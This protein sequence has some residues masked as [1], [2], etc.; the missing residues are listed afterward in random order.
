MIVR[1]RPDFRAF[2]PERAY[3]NLREGCEFYVLGIECEY[4]RIVDL[5]G[6]PILYDKELFDVVDRSITGSWSFS[7]FSEGAYFL[8]PI[9]VG[10]RGFY[11]DWHGSD[12]DV[13]AQARARQ[14]VH[15][16][17]VRLASQA[18]KDEAALIEETIRRLVK[19]T[20]R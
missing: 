12:G 6:E 17:L 15:D 1:V 4:Y 20:P 8:E 3:V 2:D 19:A 7:E 11:E 13:A 14:A 5:R 16:A 10:G 18:S 9:G